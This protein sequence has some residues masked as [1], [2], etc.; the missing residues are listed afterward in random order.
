MTQQMIDTGTDHLLS[1]LNEGVLTLTFN[2]PEARN[3]LSGDLLQALGNQLSDAEINPDVRCVV[4]TGSGNAFCAGGDVKAMSDVNTK[5]PASP[6]E[7]LIH[8]QRLNQRSTSDR[9]NK[10]PKPTLAVIPGPRCRRGLVY[11]AGM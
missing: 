4:V 10:M 8:R 7:T 9:L 3:A 5:G 1:H 2:R 6:L 11:R